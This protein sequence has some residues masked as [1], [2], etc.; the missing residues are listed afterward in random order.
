[1]S[2]RYVAL[3]DSFTEGVG[4]EVDGVPRGWADLV[5]AALAQ[6]HGEIQYA[7]M[8]VRGRLLRPIVTDQLEAALALDPPPTL[9]TLNGGGNDM[10][11][12]GMD[13]AALAELTIG[14]AHRVRSAG[15]ELVL[16][17]GPDPS[18]RLPFGPAIHTRGQQLTT[19]IG[20]FARNEGITF[21]NAF[22]DTEIRQPGYWSADRLHLNAHG[23]RR[24]ADIA[25][26]AM[27]LP[28]APRP[29]PPPLTAATGMAGWV[30]EARYYRTHVAPWLGRRLRRASSGDQR[31]PKHPDWIT[32]TATPGAP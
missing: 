29:G 15:I 27:G 2:V 6:V 4:D 17:A 9:L 26:A 18:G 20:E 5:A 23:H 1:M 19:A 16:I 28:S 8:A 21:A 3:G 25:L 22:T 32:V 12:P 7:S 31:Q 13:A 24:V 14:A 10:L 30:E 11:R